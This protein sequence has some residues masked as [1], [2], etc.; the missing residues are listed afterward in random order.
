M[1]LKKH[2][3]S[4]AIEE[5]YCV[6][7]ILS[8]EPDYKLCWLINNSLRFSFIKDEDLSFITH[9]EELKQSF[10]LF[11]YIHENTMLTYRLIKNRSETGFYLKDLQNIDYLLHIQGGI[12]TE[13]IKIL[14]ARL[15]DIDVIRLCVPIDLSRIRQK[16]R[17]QLW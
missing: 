11:R 15:Q 8:D 2:K 4:V 6:L 14:I 17:L 1:S 12:V 3:L 5:N 9:E 16:D 7:G 13:Q 10:S